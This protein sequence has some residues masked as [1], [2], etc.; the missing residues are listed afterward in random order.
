MG[1]SSV[2]DV[3]VLTGISADVLSDSEVES[4]IVYSDQQIDD[5]LGSFSTPVPIRIRNLST[6]LTAIKVFSRPDLRFRLGQ[7]GLTE[8]DLEKNL[9]LED[10][11][12]VKSI[13]LTV[14][15]GYYKRLKA[16]S[17]AYVKREKYERFIME[18]SAETLAK[19]ISRLAVLAQKK[20]YLI[21]TRCENLVDPTSK[22][23]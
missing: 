5:D 9:E 14:S 22:G 3:R 10:Y 23:A 7:T 19:V 21:W 18:A 11:E 2:S 16:S 4:L 15:Q 17:H 6:L 8:Q 12:T 13:L 1:Y 20:V